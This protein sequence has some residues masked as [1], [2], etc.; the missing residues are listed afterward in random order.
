MGYQF[1][2]MDDSTIN[3]FTNRYIPTASTTFSFENMNVF[4]AEIQKGSYISNLQFCG[5]STLDNSKQCS[6]L[7]GGTGYTSVSLD[8]SS[9]NTSFKK[10]Q[11]VEMNGQ[12]GDVSDLV[13]LVFA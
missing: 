6:I 7:V 5:I 1:T 10:F 13:N 8:T 2:K 3:C 11:L 4:Y 9:I 12:Y